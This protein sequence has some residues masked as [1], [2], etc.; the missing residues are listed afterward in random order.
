[1]ICIYNTSTYVD[2]LCQSSKQF[3]E[4]REASCK[5]IRAKQVN[6]SSFPTRHPTLQCSVL[7]SRSSN[8]PYPLF[9]PAPLFPL[10]EA[11][12]QEMCFVV[13]SN[14][15]SPTPFC[16]SQKALNLSLSTPQNR[17]RQVSPMSSARWT[18]NSELMTQVQRE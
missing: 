15:K 4:L 12:H 6:L 17:E 1:M 11:L 10:R 2:D 9:L 16:A 18:P 3:F 8:L 5:Q 13:G 7:N 14:P